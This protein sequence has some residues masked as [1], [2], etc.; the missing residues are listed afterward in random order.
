[1]SYEQRFLKLRPLAVV[2]LIMATVVCNVANAQQK[3]AKDAI[4]D[5]RASLQDGNPADLNAA[6]GEALWKTK[7]GPKNASLEAC[8][9]G[10]GAGKVKG[11]VTSLPKYFADTNQTMDLESRLVHC[12]VTLQ[13]ANMKDF[14]AGTVYSREGQKATAVEDLVAYIY[15]ER[16]A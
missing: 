13:G 8:D 12:M 1:M 6:R 11:A 3:S 5:Y 16:V 2:S 9:L 4:D 7:R 10:L 14:S 15:D